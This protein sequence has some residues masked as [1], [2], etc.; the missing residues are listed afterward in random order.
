LDALTIKKKTLLRHGR[1][2][3]GLTRCIT[4]GGSGKLPFKIEENKREKMVIRKNPLKEG[5]SELNHLRTC[6]STNIKKQF[7]KT[8]GKIRAKKKSKMLGDVKI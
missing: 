6:A 4:I 2:A 5:E 3:K 1:K 7:A 8:S